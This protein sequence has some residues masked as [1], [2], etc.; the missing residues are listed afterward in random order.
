MHCND[1]IF[2][3]NYLYFSNNFSAYFNCASGQNNLN[4]SRSRYQHLRSS[5]KRSYFSFRKGT[6]QIN[7]VLYGGVRKAL[8]KWLHTQYHVLFRPPALLHRFL[9][10]CFLLC[11]LHKYKLVPLSFLQWKQTLLNFI[12]AVAHAATWK[13]LKFL[14]STNWKKIL[15]TV[16]IN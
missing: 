13:I 9:H 1:F 11:V 14:H 12:C 5:I 2:C 16:W 15:F 6:M 8:I 7:I 10:L 3:N 4:E